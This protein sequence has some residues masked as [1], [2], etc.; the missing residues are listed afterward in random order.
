MRYSWWVLDESSIHPHSHA[1]VKRWWVE[2][3]PNHPSIHPE[4][5]HS[6]IHHH[7]RSCS[8]RSFSSGRWTCIRSGV[9]R[10]ASKVAGATKKQNPLVIMTSSWRHQRHTF[11]NEALLRRRRTCWRRRQ[12]ALIAAERIDLAKVLSHD[13][14]IIPFVSGYHSAKESKLATLLR[15]GCFDCLWL[16][17]RW[18]LLL[19]SRRRVIG[20]G[21]WRHHS[22]KRRE[23]V[24]F[25]GSRG[26]ITAAVRL[27]IPNGENVHSPFGNFFAQ[28]DS[29]T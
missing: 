9:A 13:D 10:S 11:Q 20:D 5:I 22:R 4:L 18:L 3:H 16:L 6:F 25:R 23:R 21:W 14:V 27:Q 28:F 12:I 17:L 7:T 19:L 26:A 15:W 2:S 8:L 24:S 1:Y 29:R